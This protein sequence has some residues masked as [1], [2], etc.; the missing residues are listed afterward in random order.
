MFN[1]FGPVPADPLRD[2]MLYHVGHVQPGMM[3]KGQLVDHAMML[4]QHN[5]QFVDDLWR[6]YLDR[7]K[8]GPG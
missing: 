3:S 1:G 2:A 7:T 4:L 6:S 5:E 8:G